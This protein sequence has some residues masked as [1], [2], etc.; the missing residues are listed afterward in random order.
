MARIHVSRSGIH[1][2][3]SSPLSVSRPE[4]LDE[5]GT[6]DRRFRQLIYDLSVAG[7]QLGLARKLLAAQLGVTPPR[8]NILMVVAQY[9]GQ[10]GVSVSE[11]A[12]H[13][14]VSKAHI[15]NQVKFL[16][17]KKWLVTAPNPEDGRSRLIR[18]DPSQ[19]Y[20]LTGLAKHLHRVNDDL[21]GG[22]NR[23]DFQ[24]LSRLL[25]Q[26]VEDFEQ[27]LH[28]LVTGPTKKRRPKSSP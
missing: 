5:D 27:A 11:V 23:R 4:L 15:T 26:L 14:H 16:E 22:L 24:S 20:R 12:R 3:F 21:F 9:Q 13:L 19:E 18:I 6:S 25:M 2:G 10:Q 17:K 8:Y 1:S 28:R 7:N